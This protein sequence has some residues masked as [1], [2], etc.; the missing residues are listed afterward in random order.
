MDAVATMLRTHNDLLG[1]LDAFAI[2]HAASIGY[3][4]AIRV[5]C[6]RL[7]NYLG[8]HPAVSELDPLVLSSFVRHSEETRSPATARKHRAHLLVLLR[9]A[10]DFG[11]IPSCPESRKIR[12]PKLPAP[13]PTAWTVEEVRRIIA[14]AEKIP[15]RFRDGTP[16]G[17]Y[18]A[19]LLRI[20]WES[21]LRRSDCFRLRTGD[22]S[23]CRAVIRM[24]KTGEVHSFDLHRKTA[25]EFVALAHVRHREDV[26]ALPGGLASYRYW[27]KW[28]K[29]IAGIKSMPRQMLHQIRRSGATEWARV[30][31]A[32][33]SPYLGHK[34]ETMKRHYIDVTRLP[35]R[36]RRLPIIR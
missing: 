30:D 15:G 10:A 16:R 3:I 25:R 18:F 24:R 1:L 28:I 34:D 19:L 14:A 6:N 8:R 21:G 22:L 2:H 13:M 29:R 5:S 27:W 35:C 12:C 7:A 31:M 20:A 4:G 26:L 17:R 32:Q 36:S 9:F 33:V 23:G 11:L